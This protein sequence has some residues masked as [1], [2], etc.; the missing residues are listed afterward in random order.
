MTADVREDRRLLI[1]IVLRF[2]GKVPHEGLDADEVASV[3]DG[4]AK[5][6]RLS[7]SV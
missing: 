4:M 6:V 7:L 3:A 2:D 1:S 5:A